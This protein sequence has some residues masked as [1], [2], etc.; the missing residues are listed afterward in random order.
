MKT[1]EP[2]RITYLG[3]CKWMAEGI[4][5]NRTTKQ[6]V[7]RAVRDMNFWRAIIVN[8]R[9]RQGT[10]WRRRRERHRDSC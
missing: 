7:L 4:L 8:T 9:K 2:E 5:G 6:N 10:R 1:S 3:N